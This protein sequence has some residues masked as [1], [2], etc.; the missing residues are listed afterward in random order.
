MT[1]QNPRVLKSGITPERTYIELWDALTNGKTW[2]GEFANRRKDGSEFYEAALIMPLRG[3]DGKITH[4]VAIKEDI[5]EKKRNEEELRRYRLHL[6]ELVETRTAELEHAKRQAE[7]AN[8]SKSTF[9]ANMSHEI[10][11]P[12]NAIIASPI[13]CAGSCWRRTKPKSWI[14][15]LPPANICWASSTI[16]STCPKSKRKN[17][18]S[19]TKPLESQPLSTMSVA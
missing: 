18:N 6:E 4:Y 2:Q 19:R 1:G 14:R 9:L 17:C 3:R 5:T 15:S 7:A 8:Q 10:R 12:M 16:F 13:C 11:T